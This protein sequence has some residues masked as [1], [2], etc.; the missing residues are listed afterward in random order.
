MNK[1]HEFHVD[2]SLFSVLYFRRVTHASTLTNT[3][4]DASFHWDEYLF[5]NISFRW[6]I[7][8]LSSQSPLQYLFIPHYKNQDHFFFFRSKKKNG[9]KT[10]PFLFASISFQ[11]TKLL[12]VKIVLLALIYLR[13]VP[14]DYGSHHIRST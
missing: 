4:F 2:D 3:R 10:R 13:F 8:Q 7:P 6:I 14:F 1:N 12:T 5:E 11:M 9:K